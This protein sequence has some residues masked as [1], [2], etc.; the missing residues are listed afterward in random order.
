MTILS[1]ETP[2]SGLTWESG[3]Q[4]EASLAIFNR[5]MSG[6]DIATGLIDTTGNSGYASAG[7]RNTTRSVDLKMKDCDTAVQ[8]KRL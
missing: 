2:N 4:P 1:P 6:L 8:R 3:F 5:S 7:T